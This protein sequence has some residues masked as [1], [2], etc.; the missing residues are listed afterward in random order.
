MLPEDS[1][2]RLVAIM[3]S[4]VG[5]LPYLE[6][7]RRLL[8]GA[9]FV[10]LADRE[11]FP[12]GTKTREAVEAIVRDR[13]DRLVAAFDPDAVVIACN[14]ASQA[15]LAAV[16][17]D[18]PGLDV[19]GTVPAVKPAASD[20]KRK[21]IGVLATERSVVD[22]YLDELENR[23]ASSCRVERRG[24]QDLV[25][26]VERRFLEA[27]DSETRKVIEPHVAYLVDRGVDEIVLAC[28]HFLHVARE[29]EDLA[30][31]LSAGSGGPPVK[32]VDSREGVARRL[33]DLV[34]RDDLVGRGDLMGRDDL[35][36]GD[37]GSNREELQNRAASRDRFFLT[38]PKPFEAVYAD[39]AGRY[40]LAGPFALD[41]AKR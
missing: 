37:N 1:K 14:T 9:N 10:Y 4:G 41:G 11:G 19:I 12:Y 29:I 5:G 31:E 27:D 26:F 2:G 40:G 36:G 23:F 25:A 20:S 32:V 6:S 8:P 39:F 7:A 30:N 33:R 35:R 13:V 34:G 3:D 28:T 16:R 22:P 15:A 24:A 17:R 18:H 21:V 38:G